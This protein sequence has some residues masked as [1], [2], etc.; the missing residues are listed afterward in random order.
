M[1]FTTVF[2]NLKTRYQKKY[3]LYDSIYLKYKIESVVLEVRIMVILGRGEYL[4]RDMNKLQGS[5][6]H[7]IF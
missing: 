3:M 2:K 6:L 5:C 4:E 1:Y 7:S